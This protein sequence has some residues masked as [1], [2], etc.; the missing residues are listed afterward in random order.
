VDLRLGQDAGDRDLLRRQRGCASSKRA[1]LRAARV[2]LSYHGLVGD[3]TALLVANAPFVWTT[4]LASLAASADQLLAADGGANHLARL[5]LRP[6]AVIG[7]LDSISDSVRSWLGEERMVFRPDQERTDLDKALEHVFEKLGL[8]RLT[9]LAALGGRHD[10][11]LGNLGLLAQ[12]GLGDRLVYEG[13]DHR[14]VAI[15][16]EA[17]LTSGSGE[18]WS[19]WTFDPAVRVTID[20]VRWPVHEASLDAGSRPSISNEATGNVLEV[21]ARGGAVI[22]MRHHTGVATFKR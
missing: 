4:Q 15:A 12:R 7:D 13:A 19:F 1:G 22:A 14:V 9:V 11:D 16:G 6:A 8:G 5:G 20:G 2:F 3:G 18:R 17:T 21:R 10:H